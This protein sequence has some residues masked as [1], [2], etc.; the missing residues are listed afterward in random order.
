MGGWDTGLR[1]GS[2]ETWSRPR[3]SKALDSLHE[4]KTSI[5]DKV[6][7]AHLH[8][9]EAVAWSAAQQDE[10]KRLAAV[11]QKAP[12]D[13]TEDEVK[14]VEWLWGLGITSSWGQPSGRTTG[15]CTSLHA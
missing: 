15:P 12:A 9:K 10:E 7:R 3:T 1:D 5:A 14:W 6:R 8:S 11:C 13:R 2:T 4:A